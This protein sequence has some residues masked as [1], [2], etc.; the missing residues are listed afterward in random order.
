MTGFNWVSLNF[1]GVYLVFTWF[2]W[3]LMIIN[4][5]LLGYIEFQWVILDFTG[6]TGIFLALSGF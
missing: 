4:L 5:F 1:T 2:Y 6:F 3:V